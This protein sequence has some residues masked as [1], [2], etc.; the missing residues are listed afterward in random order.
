MYVDELIQ[1]AVLRVGEVVRVHGRTVTVEVD[2]EKN[3]SDLMFA[4]EVIRNISV[5]SFVEIRK[6]FLSLIGGK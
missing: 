5:N 2:K 1:D 3:R 6:G 4:G